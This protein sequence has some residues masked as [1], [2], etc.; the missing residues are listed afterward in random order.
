MVALVV[1]A[2]AWPRNPFGH[3]GDSY[4]TARGAAHW[5]A[6]MRDDT[7]SRV[8]ILHAAATGTTV[9][10]RGQLL[11]T[12]PASATPIPP[13]TLIQ[14]APDAATAAVLF[15]PASGVVTIM[16]SS[17]LRWDGDALRPLAG[18]FTV[19]LASDAV[20]SL[21]D[22]LPHR[23]VFPAGICELVT[24]EVLVWAQLDRRLWL[25]QTRG[26]SY[27]KGRDSALLRIEA[28]RQVSLASWGAKIP[29]ATNEIG[30]AGV[31]SFWSWTPMPRF[32]GT[33]VASDTMAPAVKRRHKAA[34][35]TANL[36]ASATA[37][38]TAEDDLIQEPFTMKDG[39]CHIP[40][41]PGLGITLDE[42]AVDRYR[43]R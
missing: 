29:D 20:A 6:P 25:A 33:T 10:L 13:Y 19:A 37:A 34:S 18:R 28:H 35:G 30:N 43:V 32:G 24:G 23:L 22:A 5:R 27:L 31:R 36:A 15:T 2:F 1:G 39:L 42:A 4:R 26:V 38:V 11:D 8:A 21:P 14:V 41:K 7:A 17:I 40:D 12:T 9:R 3:R 16:P